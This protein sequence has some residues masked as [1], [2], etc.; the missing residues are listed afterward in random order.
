LK[1]LEKLTA[2]ISAVKMEVNYFER[3]N[4]WVGVLPSMKIKAVS[5]SESI[6]FLP[7]AHHAKTRQP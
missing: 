2:C 1:D 7:T 3:W 6:H 5:F 4:Y